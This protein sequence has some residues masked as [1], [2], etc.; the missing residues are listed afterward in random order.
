MN[1]ASVRVGREELNQFI[2][3]YNSN[4]IGHF[5]PE[6]K[7]AFSDLIISTQDEKELSG[8]KLKIMNK[9]NN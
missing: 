4:A 7:K 1:K 5:H 2:K 3:K 6:L 9:T 8:K